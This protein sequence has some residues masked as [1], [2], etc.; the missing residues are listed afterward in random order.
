MSLS[1]F[2][3][4]KPLC[5]N[6]AFFLFVFPFLFNYLHSA[7]HTINGTDNTCHKF[8]VSS[9]FILSGEDKQGIIIAKTCSIWRTSVWNYALHFKLIFIDLA[10]LPKKEFLNLFL[11]SFFFLPPEF[12]RTI[13]EQPINLLKNY[14]KKVLSGKWITVSR[15]SYYKTAI[16]WL[17]CS[18]YSDHYFLLKWCL[19]KILLS[20]PSK[21]S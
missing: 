12:S 21:W 19:D 3:S 15:H 14:A 10:F 11:K 5:W 13:Y 17:G 9:F 20:I 18:L 8:S 7:V 16:C 2:V 4:K 1:M 6:A